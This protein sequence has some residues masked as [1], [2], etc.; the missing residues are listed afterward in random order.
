VWVTLRHTERAI[1]R[2]IGLD[3]KRLNVQADEKLTAFLNLKRR[4]GLLVGSDVRINSLGDL[5]LKNQWLS[6]IGSRAASNY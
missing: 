4:F 6:P 3:D 1:P 5:S 2:S